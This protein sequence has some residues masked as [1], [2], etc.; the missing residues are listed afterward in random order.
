[1]TMEN[2]TATAKAKLADG[3]ENDLFDAIDLH[4]DLK[5]ALSKLSGYDLLLIHYVFMEE[6]SL[7]DVASLV[8]ISRQ[9]VR[10][11]IDRTLKTLRKD[12]E[13]EA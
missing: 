6:Q 2:S 1:M 5:A 4:L 7:D 13:G 11:Q 12:L 10:K 9:A 8:G 3:I